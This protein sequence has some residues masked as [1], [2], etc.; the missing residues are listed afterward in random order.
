MG[1]NNERKRGD[2]FSW[3]GEQE[4]EKREDISG[5]FLP[6]KTLHRKQISQYA[7]KTMHI[8]IIQEFA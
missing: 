3:E 4:L 6:V 8:L 5:L 1:Y 7:V 2:N